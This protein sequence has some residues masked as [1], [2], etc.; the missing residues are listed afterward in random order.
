MT[1]KKADNKENTETGSKPKPK[2]KPPGKDPSKMTFA[3]HF[4]ELR[5]RLLRCVISVVVLFVICYILKDYIV[6][7][8][9]RPYEAFREKVVAEGG[10]DPGAL[11]FIGPTEGFIFYLKTSF[12]AALFFSA[13]VI[14][15]QM[16]LFIGAGLYSK[17]KK[18]IMRIVPFSILLFLSGLAFGYLVLFPIG[19]SFLVSF[20][21]PD[22]IVA[23]I[24]VS[25]YC[26]LFF[27]LILIMGFM[28]QAPLVMVV[29]T[30]IGLTTPELF[31][32]KR[33]YFLLGAFICAAMFTPPDAITQC[34]LAGPLL[35]LFEFGILLSR[36]VVKK[37]KERDAERDGPAETDLP[38]TDKA[39]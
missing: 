29:T 36:R 23:S 9:L 7:F 8:I 32:S 19:L 3:E 16:W 38:A 14:L 13:P 34:L 6:E 24:T 39:G 20:P 5:T 12:M 21:D 18:S 25:K 1:E 35:I 17:E 4:V 28:F 27:L 26:D 11:V 15:Y 33:R 30:S 10:K 31:T 22:I 2:V 37:Q